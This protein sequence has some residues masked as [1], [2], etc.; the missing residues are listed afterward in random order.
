MSPQRTCQIAHAGQTGDIH[1]AEPLLQTRGAVKC[2]LS[3]HMGQGAS[4]AAPSTRATQEQTSAQAQTQSSEHQEHAQGKALNCPPC[5][6]ILPQAPA[7]VPSPHWPS[8]GGRAQTEEQHESN[9]G[10]T[11]HIG[12]WRHSAAP[13]W[14]TMQATADQGLTAPKPGRAHHAA[15]ARIGRLAPILADTGLSACPACAH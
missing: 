15:G 3:N 8:A 10:P 14:G 1:T 2:R 6:H 4:K 11:E 13:G 12:I 7:H 9:D 5:R